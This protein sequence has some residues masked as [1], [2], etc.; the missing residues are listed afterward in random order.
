MIP[1]HVAEPYNPESNIAHVRSPR[2]SGAFL[3]LL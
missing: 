1:S 3:E 2:N